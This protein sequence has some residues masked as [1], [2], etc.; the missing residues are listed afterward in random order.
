MDYWT[1]RTRGEL[2]RWLEKKYH[3]SC[4]RYCSD[5]QLRAIYFK[6]IEQHDK[7]GR[8]GNGIDIQRS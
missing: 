4:F 6:T 7:T 8:V 2:I 5:K 3:G 1:P